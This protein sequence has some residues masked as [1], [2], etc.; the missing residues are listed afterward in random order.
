MLKIE[1]KKSAGFT[2]IEL[3]IVVVIIA[4]F[5]AIALP[6][7][8]YYVRKAGEAEAR[9]VMLS[10]SNDLEKWSAKTLSFRGFNPSYLTGGDVRRI[11]L[12]SNAG[13]KYNITVKDAAGTAVVALND[14]AAKGRYWRMLAEPNSSHSTLKTAHKFYIDSLGAKCMFS[15]DVSVDI[16]KTKVCNEAT[17]QAWK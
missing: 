16:T 6:S 2:L 17:A 1:Q 4:I 9:S 12:D 3:M 15:A 7:Y 10:I 14:A 5:A 13:L 11:P 8:Q